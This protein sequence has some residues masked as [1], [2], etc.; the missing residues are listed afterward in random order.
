L[1][2]LQDYDPD[3]G[4]IGIYL[5]AVVESIPHGCIPIRRAASSLICAAKYHLEHSI[6]YLIRPL[7]M[8]RDGK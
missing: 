2:S 5:H 3:L 1:K 4:R 8:G 7:E 6:Q